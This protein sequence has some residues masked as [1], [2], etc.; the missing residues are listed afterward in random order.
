MPKNKRKLAF[1]RSHSMKIDAFA[2]L[3]QGGE[4]T[5]KTAHLAYRSLCDPIRTQILNW[6]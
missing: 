2:N 1:F 3:R 6:E 5:P 4:S